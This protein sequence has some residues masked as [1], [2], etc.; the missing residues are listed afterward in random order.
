MKGG[1]HFMKRVTDKQKLLC[2]FNIM[3][4]KIENTLSME[5]TDIPKLFFV[6]HNASC[7]YTNV[8]WGQCD[9]PQATVTS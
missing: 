4:A 7:Y 5:H 1:V 3:W 6:S 2:D 8:T 9:P